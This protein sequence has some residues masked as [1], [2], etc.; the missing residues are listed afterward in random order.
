MIELT[1]RLAAGRAPGHSDPTSTGD[2][3]TPT[4]AVIDGAHHAPQ[5]TLA[6]AW[7]QAIEHHPGGVDGPQ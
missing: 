6:D 1:R 4:A 3:A 5:L 2:A 7:C